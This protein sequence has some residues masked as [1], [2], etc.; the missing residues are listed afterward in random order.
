MGG[1]EGLFR[2][3]NPLGDPAVL[4]GQSAYPAIPVVSP[5]SVDVAIPGVNNNL[6]FTSRQPGEDL[7]GLTVQLFSRDSSGP[8]TVTWDPF[9]N[10]LLIDARPDTT[11]NDVLALLNGPDVTGVTT[12]AEAAGGTLPVGLYA[13]KVSFLDSTGAEGNL[14]GPSSLGQVQSNGSKV[15]LS[16]QRPSSKER[17]DGSNTAGH[18]ANRKPYE[19]ESF[20]MRW[21][22]CLPAL[23]L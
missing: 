6:T 22:A 12:K 11:A 16:G 20:I 21:R 17:C 9:G 13:Y 7:N 3:I 5:A 14:S 15:T 1:G 8:A 18:P 23:R 10:R 19:I 4:G 2:V